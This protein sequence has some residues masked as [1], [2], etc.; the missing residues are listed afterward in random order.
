M[1]LAGLL[2]V[3]AG[4]RTARPLVYPPIMEP[5]SMGELRGFLRESPVPVLAVFV[6]PGCS[7]C[8]S[9][10]PLLGRVMDDY[11]RSLDVARVDLDAV[12]QAIVEYDLLHVPTAIVFDR[13]REVSRRRGIQPQILFYRFIDD[14]LARAR[15]E[16]RQAQP[17]PR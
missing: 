13:G 1:A 2:A 16:R 12:G 14:A 10:L 7:S 11:G 8:E 9:V 15:E 4:C 5:Q 3:A 17:T 6:S